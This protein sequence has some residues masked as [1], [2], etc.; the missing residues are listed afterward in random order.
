MRNCNG[1]H[2]DLLPAFEIIRAAQRPVLHTIRYYNAHYFTYLILNCANSFRH[3][4]HDHGH[5]SKEGRT[6]GLA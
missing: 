1:A 5:Q 6:V 3:Y 2:C 4:M